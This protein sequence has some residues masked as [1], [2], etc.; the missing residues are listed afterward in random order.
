MLWLQN[1][2]SSSSPSTSFSSSSKTDDCDAAALDFRKIDTCEDQHQRRI[3]RRG[4]RIGVSGPTLTRARKLRHLTEYDVAASSSLRS[5]ASDASDFAP[6]SLSA[7]SYDQ[8]ATSKCSSVVAVPLPL[9]LPEG[10]SDLADG[11]GRLRATKEAGHGRGVEERERDGVR[12]R[13]KERDGTDGA[14]EGMLSNSP[15]ASIFAGRDKKA[16]EYSEMRPSRI[17]SPDLNSESYRENFSLSGP[18]R[19]VPNSP[20][21]S[22]ILAPPRKSNAGL[23]PYHHMVPK[24]NQV[25]SAPEMLNVDT[26]GLPP[27]A[28]FDHT[29]FSTDSSPLHSPHNRSPRRNLRSPS[30]PTS[31]FH[32]RLSLDT[33]APRREGSGHTEVH[34]LPLPPGAAL[35][36]PTAPMSQ[37]KGKAESLPMNCQWQKGK[38]I[39]RGTFGSVYVASNRE[40]GALCA[41]KEVELFPD[42]P[43]SAECIKQLEQE[44]KVLSK[45]KHPN[46]VQYYGSEIVD[47]RL[48]IYLEYVHPGSINKYVREH[49]GAITE[50]VVRNFT[51]HI[52]SGLAYLHS[53][54]T[55]HRDIKGANLLVDAAGVVKLADFG[56]AKHL[57]GAAA[58]L[59]MKGSPYWMAPELM[60]A[61]MQKDTNSDLAFAVDIWS[62]GCTIIEM[63]TGK[64]P[65]SEFEGAAAMFKVM[66][67]TPA[68]PENFSL[69]GKDFLRCCFR[70]NPAERPTANML[71]EHRFMKSLNLD[72]TQS[73]NGMKLMEKSYSPR[74]QTEAKLQAPRRQD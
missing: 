35:P 2:F 47:D 40:T 12:D 36:S 21:A 25:W 64:P 59:S 71:L 16:K 20:F 9:P 10:K 54:K 34:P 24:G 42:D 41:M 48:Y 44:I 29:A 22:P 30:R 15:I 65:W 50:S 4:R 52:L 72:V 8:T 63:L 60:Q 3:H 73:L 14:G 51:R 31:P 37:P 43:K 18:A 53:T 1:I 32:T 7:S 49:C 33:S 11:E 62:L 26:S 57:T 28:F 5:H 69:E 46:I 70:R 45:L 6:L 67:D 23:F 55:I 66:K 68:I 39:G 56:T 27:P 58:D 19:S 13:G 61:V 17:V 38:L 74:E